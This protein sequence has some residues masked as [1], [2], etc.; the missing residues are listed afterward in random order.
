MA[1]ELHG[2][3]RKLRSDGGE[4]PNEVIRIMTLCS[5]SVSAFEVGINVA[6]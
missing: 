3:E 5:A 1:I 4:S 2:S 6:G